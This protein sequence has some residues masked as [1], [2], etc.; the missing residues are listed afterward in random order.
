MEGTSKALGE[1]GQ[2]VPL[3]VPQMWENAQASLEKV[4]KGGWEGPS[5][6]RRGA[7]GGQVEV[8]GMGP[9]GHAGEGLEGV[10]EQWGQKVSGKD[11]ENNMEL[12]AGEVLP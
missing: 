6:R 4:V 9:R 11:D 7:P 2:L 8:Q 5:Q 1:L 3:G 12:R 10:Q